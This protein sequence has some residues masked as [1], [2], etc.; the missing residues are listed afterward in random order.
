MGTA[1]VR[2]DGLEDLYGGEARL[3]TALLNSVPQAL[4]PRV[5]VGDAKQRRLEVAIGL[6]GDPELVSLIQPICFN[7]GRL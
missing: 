3:V 7:D 1:Y 4:H 2:L 6:A 5:G